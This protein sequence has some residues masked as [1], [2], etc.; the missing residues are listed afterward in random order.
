LPEQITQANFETYEGPH[1]STDL[2]KSW[3]SF[4]ASDSTGRIRKADGTLNEHATIASVEGFFRALASHFAL[5]TG[6]NF[7]VETNK[8]LIAVCGDIKTI[9]N[10]T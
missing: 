7:S 5:K 10:K 8:E 3:V 1:P 9:L 2:L 6:R 4:Y